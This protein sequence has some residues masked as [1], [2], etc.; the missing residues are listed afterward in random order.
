MSKGSKRRPGKGYDDNYEKIFS[1]TQE[2]GSWV[3]CPVRCKLIPKAEYYPQEKVS[4]QIMPDI[5]PFVSPVDG[6]VITSRTKLRAHNRE[7]GVTNIRDY[8]EETRM[9]GELE[10]QKRITGSTPQ[11]KRERKMLIAEELRKRGVL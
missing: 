6:K 2:R 3:Y 9:K 11:A 8:G 1:G 4:V 7:H 10:R 5:Q